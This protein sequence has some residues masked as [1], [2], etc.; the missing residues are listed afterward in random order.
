MSLFG[1]L[2]VGATGMRAHQAGVSVTSH[3]L[4]NATTEGYSRQRL[5]IQPLA[6]PLAGGA[7]AVGSQRVGDQLVERRLLGAR[8]HAHYAEARADLGRSVDQLFADVQ[9]GIGDRIDAFQQALADFSTYPDDPTVRGVVLQSATDLVRSF[10]RAAD[11]LADVEA[12]ANTKIQ[13]GVT[14]VNGMLGEIAD[15]GL[16]DLRTR[17]SA[18]ATSVRSARPARPVDP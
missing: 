1:V 10:G 18:R 5:E 2:N 11:T 16:P 8:S 17:E 4:A 12:E 7:R 9:G 14:A 15:L 13:G 6:H 3:N